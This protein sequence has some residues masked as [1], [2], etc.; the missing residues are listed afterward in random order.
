MS[1]R[2]TKNAAWKRK[3]KEKK[4]I[5]KTNRCVINKRIKREEEEEY[6]YP[7]VDGV[8]W[9]IMHQDW[10]ELIKYIFMVGP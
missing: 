10:R 3:E 9:G 4:S 5:H 6:S 1:L 7:N 8:P 2:G